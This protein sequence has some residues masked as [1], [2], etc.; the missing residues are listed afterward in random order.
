MKEHVPKWLLSR[1]N[2]TQGSVE[3]AGRNPASSIAK[4]LLETG[5]KVDPPRQFEVIFR[6]AKSRILAIAEA[7]AIRKYKPDLCVHKSV[8][9]ALR[10][11]WT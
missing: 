3:T 6:C 11:P 8:F 5:H 1:L 4:H 7:L 10:L 2:E 9:V